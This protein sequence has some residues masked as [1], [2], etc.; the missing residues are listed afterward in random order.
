MCWFERDF[1]CI[2][3]VLPDYHMAI[4]INTEPSAIVNCGMALPAQQLKVVPIQSDR[5]VIDVL[6]CKKDLV[7]YDLP[8]RVSSVP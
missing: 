3:S 8:C 5:L 2:D 4:L 6:F 1:T 7:V